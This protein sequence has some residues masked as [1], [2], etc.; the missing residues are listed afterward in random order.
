MIHRNSVF[1]RLLLVAALAA[2]AL[3]SLAQTQELDPKTGLPKQP[4][5]TDFPDTAEGR[6][7]KWGLTE[8]PGLDPDPKKVFVRNGKEFTIEKYERRWAVYEDVN[9][10]WVRPFGNVNMTKEVYRDDGK[11]WIW[12]FHEVSTPQ[13][14]RELQEK[15]AREAITDEH[16][17]IF[18]E[19]RPEFDEL[20][21]PSATKTL[22]FEPASNGLPREG[23]WRNGLDVADMNGDGHLDLVVP[24]QRGGAAASPYIFLGDSRGNWK[25]WTEVRFSRGVSYGTVVASDFNKDGHQDLAFA[26][27]LAG[28]TAFLGDGKGN[29]KES[30]QGLSTRTFP[31]RRLVT[32]DVNRDGY[33]DLVVISEGPTMGGSDSGREGRLRVYVNEAKGSRWRELKVVDSMKSIGGDFLSAGDLNGDRIPDFLG[34]SVYFNGP[35]ILNVSKGPLK[36]ETVGQ[37]KVAPYYS[38]YSANA[39]GKFTGRKTD[40]FIVSFRRSWPN[41]LDERVVERPKNMNV[42]GID[43]ITWSG[44]E[45]K[46]IPIER[47]VDEAAI[48]GLAQG[49]FDGDRKSDIVYSR[50]KPRA[51]HFLLGDGKGKFAKAEAEGLELRPN[52]SYDIKVADVNKDGRPDIIVM[53]EMSES[54]LATAPKDGSIEVFLNRGAK[55][56]VV[57]AN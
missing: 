37:G 18:A 1:L 25:A 5:Y 57:A 26:V 38:Y 45:P 53:Y 9:S 44:K 29:F 28:V 42:A 55:S 34:A 36:W 47:W 22:H 10:G 46:R 41:T 6:M 39:S 4:A 15:H 14:I 54:I 49:D 48:W 2:T 13:S 3:P 7:K 50:L 33:P 30:S 17:K 11:Q 43:L 27:H 21:V 12:V 56:G 35:D 40:D 23:S 20:A 31:T 19:L 51:F 8:D 24:P 52:M 16:R 32:S